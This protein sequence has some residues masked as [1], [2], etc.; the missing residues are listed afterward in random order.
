MS[1]LDVYVYSC[2]LAKGRFFI[3][4]N[5]TK[6]KQINIKGLRQVGCKMDN[7]GLQQQFAALQEEQK[8]KLRMVQQRKTQQKTPIKTVRFHCS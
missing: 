1:L 6:H 7:E 2:C 8:R 3:G 5:W 4:Q